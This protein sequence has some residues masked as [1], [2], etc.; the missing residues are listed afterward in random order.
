MSTN[1]VQR[2]KQIEALV[3]AHDLI[4]NASIDA[5]NTI[6]KFN[7]VVSFLNSIPETSSLTSILS[8][9]VSKSL[10]LIDSLTSTAIDKAPT[11]NQAKLLNDA[12]T[13]LSNSFIIKLVTTSTTLISTDRKVHAT[14]S[15]ASQV[16][17]LPASPASGQSHT[18]SISKNS[19]ESLEINGNGKNI[20]GSA[21][22]ILQ[23]NTF[24]SVDFSVSITVIYNGSSWELV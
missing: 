22:Y 3:N 14:I 12:I 2:I 23:K 16:L 7:E 9:Y 20:D 19:T 5:D 1:L 10:D 21:T 4:L 15:S 13:T 8:S 18:I 11:A 17:T 24:N 6:N